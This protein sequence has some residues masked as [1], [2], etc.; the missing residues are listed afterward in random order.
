MLGYEDLGWAYWRVI[1]GPEGLGFQAHAD[2]FALEFLILPARVGFVLNRG[3]LFLVAKTFGYP[4][5]FFWTPDSESPGGSP[6]RA[7]GGFRS[8]RA[9]RAA[10]PG[11]L[12][13]ALGR[14][15]GRPSRPRR[16]GIHQEPS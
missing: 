7:T 5:G 2:T 8:D 10:G 1:A 13:L 11:A 3:S 12:A 14:L 4:D 16:S 15:G 6:S 9:R